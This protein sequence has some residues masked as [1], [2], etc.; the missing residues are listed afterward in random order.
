MEGNGV[1]FICTPRIAPL[2]YARV[3]IVPWVLP[4]EVLCQSLG[5]S[6][7][8]G[9]VLAVAAWPQSENL[10]SQQ[11]AVV[12]PRGKGATGRVQVWKTS[13]VV[14][15]GVSRS[16]PPQAMLK[17]EHV[18]FRQ[19]KASDRQA[20]GS[21]WLTKL[22]AEISLYSLWSTLPTLGQL[23]PDVWYYGHLRQR[24]NITKHS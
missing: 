5:T 15:L 7:D 17:A 10:T 6:A 3:S 1:A 16:L 24:F 22:M 2:L 11:A 13:Y 21:L 19:K 8:V 12:F 18:C 20:F 14:F 4:P 23:C 9:S